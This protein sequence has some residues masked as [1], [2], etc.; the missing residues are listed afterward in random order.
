VKSLGFVRLT[1]AI[2]LD[3]AFPSKPDWR[4]EVKKSGKRV[5]ISMCT[6]IF[7]ELKV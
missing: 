3:K 7:D 4:G 2:A 6:E 1:E 5:I